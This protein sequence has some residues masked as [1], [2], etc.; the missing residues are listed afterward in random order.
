MPAET[1]L[2]TVHLNEKVH[3]AEPRKDD[4]AMFAE[5]A[6]VNQG[7]RASGCTFFDCFTCLYHLG[8][9]TAFS[10]FLLFLHLLS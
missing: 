4:L 9:K 7:M 2:K 6:W 10:G 8:I 1:I 3:G 5:M